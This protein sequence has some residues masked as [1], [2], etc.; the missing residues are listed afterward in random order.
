M[1]KVCGKI[2]PQELNEKQKQKRVEICQDLLEGQDDILGRG[3]TGD[4]TWVYQYVPEKKRQSAQWK[5][6]NSPR[7]KNFRQSK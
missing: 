2:A 6:T 1:R 4:E 3:I 5:T 7:P